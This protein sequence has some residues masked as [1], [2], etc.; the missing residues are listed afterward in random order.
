[1]RKGL[2]LLTAVVA[3]GAS[4]VYAA[5][6]PNIGCAI[7]KFDDTFMT[8]VRNAI[9]AAAQGKA[10]VDIV[11]SQNS[12]ATQNE[13]ID[14]FITKKVSR[15]IAINQVDR[16]ARRRHHRARPRRPTS[17]WC[18][19]T[20][21]VAGR[22]G[23]VRQGLL[24]RRQRR[25]VRHDAGPAGRRLLEGASRGRQERR[26]RHP[27]RHAV[28]ASRPPGRRAPHRV[29]HQGASTTPAS[30]SRSSPRRSATGIARRARSRWAPSTPR[31]GRHR[32]RL[33]QQRRHGPRAPSRPSRR[34]ATSR[35]ASSCPSSAS[36]PPRPRSTSC[37]DGDPAR[38][39]PQRRQEPGHGHLQPRLR[40]GHGPA[41][42]PRRT[43]ATS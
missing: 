15:R 31:T 20:G 40:A 39:R 1:M 14:L 36:T 13:Q 23:E 42:R 27:V 43:S 9:L 16:A 28:R 5:A 35:A 34:T 30:R 41:P 3:L 10:K 4:A 17:R 29:L 21:A 33:R 11:D 32:V 12:Q 38:H 22:H 25:G 37:E 2:L 7:Y 26:R 6:M 18:S 8:G 19:S 24:R